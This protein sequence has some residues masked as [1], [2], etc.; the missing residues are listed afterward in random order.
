MERL[1]QFT[2]FGVAL[3]ALA[4]LVTLAGEG[5]AVA[6]AVRA[7]LVQNVDE[8]GRHPY[9][10]FRGDFVCDNTQN[11]CTLKFSPV[12][13]GKRLVLTNVNGIVGIAPV[14][15][16]GPIFLLSTAQHFVMYLPALFTS[17]TSLNAIVNASLKTYFEAGDV[18]VLGT[19]VQNQ[20]GTIAATLTGY[21]IDLP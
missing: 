15:F 14:D 12:P 2:W 19:Q 20:Y 8:P 21:Y 10:E 6:Q 1:K 9:I 5:R 16:K 4:V 18:P 13:A 7:A 11:I 17:T 3:T